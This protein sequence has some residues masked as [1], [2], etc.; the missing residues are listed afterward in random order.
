MRA[1]TSRS[2]IAG[3]TTKVDRLPALA[4]DLARRQVS[5][6]TTCGGERDVFAAK[7]ATSKIP[8]VFIVGGDPVKAGFVA[9]LGRPGGQPN[10]REYVQR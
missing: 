6:I 1:N 8:I 10:R 9:S 2:T 7:A 5:V 3:Q 4:V